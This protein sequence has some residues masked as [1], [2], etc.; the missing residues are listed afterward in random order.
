MLE[1]A[2]IDE[3]HPKASMLADAS[4]IHL[5]RRREQ[6]WSMVISGGIHSPT[7]RFT[8]FQA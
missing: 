1:L 2:C 6:L 5:P 8:A 4:L 7:R 3:H